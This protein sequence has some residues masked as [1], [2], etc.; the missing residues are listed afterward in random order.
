MHD[1][2][3]AFQ[4]AVRVWPDR[5]RPLSQTFTQLR[6]FRL[7]CVVAA[8]FCCFAARFN[9]P[10]ESVDTHLIRLKLRTIM[11][12][13]LNPGS[14]SSYDLSGTV[15]T[16]REVSLMISKQSCLTTT[17]AIGRPDFWN[18]Q[19]AS[20]SFAARSRL[21][22]CPQQEFESSISD[23]PCFRVCGGRLASLLEWRVAHALSA[24][25]GSRDRN[26][27]PRRNVT[28]TPSAR[29]PGRGRHESQ[30]VPRFCCCM[31]LKW[32]ERR[33]FKL[34]FWITSRAMNLA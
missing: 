27:A 32:A 17:T 31:Y 2:T 20:K 15:L 10:S 23:A 28:A 13:T 24:H 19:E 11:I 5:A 3:S 4:T 14:T 30:I 9:A 6:P 7:L 22:R 29:A 21:E 1:V 25:F 12:E 26:A 34:R 16:P 33:G 18:D 8:F